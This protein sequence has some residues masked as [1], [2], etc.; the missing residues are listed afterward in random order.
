MNSFQQIPESFYKQDVL[1][2]APA[3]LGKVIIFR[4][5][6]QD[7]EVVRYFFISETEAYRGE[8]DLACH[9]SKGKTTRT[10]VM[11]HSGGVYYV[12]LIY[13]MYWML[14]IVTGEKDMPQAV[15]IRGVK[16]FD[17]ES[18]KIVNDFDGPGKVGKLLKINKSFYGTP[19]FDHPDFQIFDNGTTDKP[20]ARLPRVGVDYA[21]PVWSKKPWRFRWE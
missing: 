14:N 18:G 5:P 3:L 2:V 19:V 7:H 15:L 11:Y 8:E 17:P 6:V 20:F 1:E 4:Q 12:Y 13:G 16:E 9:C 21:G 10:E